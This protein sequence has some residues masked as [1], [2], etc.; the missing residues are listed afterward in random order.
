MGLATV[1]LPE[2]HV[3]DGKARLH[4]NRTGKSQTL[5]LMVLMSRPASL[6]VL[7]T[8]TIV[9]FSLVLHQLVGHL[10]RVIHIVPQADPMS[11]GD[12]SSSVPMVARMNMR[13]VQTSFKRRS[14]PLFLRPLASIKHLSCSPILSQRIIRLPAKTCH[15]SCLTGYLRSSN[16]MS[17]RLR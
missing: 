14:Y 11:L 10:P 17:F 12:S 9:L 6:S 2:P 5:A 13:M 16:L 15:P 8:E 4:A 1:V 7:T 3:I